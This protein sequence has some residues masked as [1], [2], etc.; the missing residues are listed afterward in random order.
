MSPC[1]QVRGLHS[2]P[3]R[4][5]LIPQRDA[6]TAARMSMY[7]AKL[8]CCVLCPVRSMEGPATSPATNA[9]HFAV[10]LC[11]P[12]SPIISSTETNV[13]AKVPRKR[14]YL[15]VSLIAKEIAS[16]LVNASTFRDFLRSKRA[17][18]EKRAKPPLRPAPIEKPLAEATKILRNLFESTK[19]T[20]SEPRAEGEDDKD[21]DLVQCLQVSSWDPGIPFS[22]EEKEQ[23]Q[24]PLMAPSPSGDMVV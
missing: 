7:M 6:N 5:L 10:L 17:R 1:F 16:L 8:L 12:S 14:P 3:N 13:P 15:S 19:R 20:E 22:P 2:F 18:I 11:P 9:L 24:Q 23:G 21:L 4:L